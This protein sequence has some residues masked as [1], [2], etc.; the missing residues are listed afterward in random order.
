MQ[1]HIT[2]HAYIRTLHCHAHTDTPH[3]HTHTRMIIYI[4]TH[5]QPHIY[6]TDSH[7]RLVKPYQFKSG[8]SNINAILVNTRTIP[9]NYN[10]FK[11]K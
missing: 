1:T 7:R 8:A 9:K 11:S 6:I 3:I 10:P 4:L 5:N 2:M